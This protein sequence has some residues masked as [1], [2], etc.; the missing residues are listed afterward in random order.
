MI[1]PILIF[2]IVSGA[3]SPEPDSSGPLKEIGHVRASACG[4]VVV[5]ANAAI[6]AALHDD[7]LI[8]RSI[9]R[10]RNANLED[11][12]L[13]RRQAMNDLEHLAIQLRESEMAGV[14]EAKR[15]R[16]MASK[17][18]DPTQKV[19]LKTFADALGGALNRQSKIAADF[20]GLL[21]Y[22]DYQEALTP[23][24]TD[25][26]QFASNSMEFTGGAGRA[27]EMAA[28]QRAGGGSFEHAS[29]NQLLLAAASDFQARLID[30]QSDEAKAANHT[31][32]AVSGC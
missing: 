17:S 18:P 29:P 6:S 3:A 1:F 20:N 25:A 14:G 32:G 8:A 24:Q 12:A 2:V 7:F 30:V 10:M 21:A 16:D 5:H 23:S 26:Q 9:A 15:L 27:T 4:A 28:A 22:L 19:E 31:D 11:N 13:S